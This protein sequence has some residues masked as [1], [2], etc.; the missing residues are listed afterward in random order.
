MEKT[1]ATKV[2]C[3]ACKSDRGVKKT[4]RFVFISG[5]VLFGLAIYGGIKLVQDIMS[6]F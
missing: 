5:G 6:L 3:Q 4:K 1:E 2:G